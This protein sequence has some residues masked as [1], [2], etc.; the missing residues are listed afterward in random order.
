MLELVHH[1]KPTMYHSGYR[2]YKIHGMD[3]VHLRVRIN[4]HKNYTENT[5]YRVA[6]YEILDWSSKDDILSSDWRSLHRDK[7]KDL[8]KAEVISIQAI[9]EA[10]K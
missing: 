5:W 6:T 8:M 9:R 7:V 4:R 2:V 1:K 10:L 3:E